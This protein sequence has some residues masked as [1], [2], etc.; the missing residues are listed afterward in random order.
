MLGLRN[1]K[2]G[3]G[4][5]VADDV[6]GDEVR[7]KFKPVFV[8]VDQVSCALHRTPGNGSVGFVIHHQVLN[9]GSDFVQNK[10]LP[11]IILEVGISA[12]GLQWISTRINGQQDVGAVERDGG[13]AH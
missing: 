5:A 2:R 10:A 4:F 9:V 7:G 1:L 11:L 3:V 8:A 6:K 13:V 12:A